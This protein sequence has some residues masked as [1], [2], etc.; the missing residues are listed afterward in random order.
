[1]APAKQELQGDPFGAATLN[2]TG[3]AAAT[4][5][6]YGIWR[7]NEQRHHPYCETPFMDGLILPSAQATAFNTKKKDSSPGRTILWVLFDW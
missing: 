2:R 5:V 6:I 3:K 7:F 1:M 4:T